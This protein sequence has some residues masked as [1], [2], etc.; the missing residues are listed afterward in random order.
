[1]VCDLAPLAHVLDG[2]AMRKRAKVAAYAYGYSRFKLIQAE[3]DEEGCGAVM[4]AARIA[5]AIEDAL[6]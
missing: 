2:L 6:E 1:M 5:V 3:I 4:C